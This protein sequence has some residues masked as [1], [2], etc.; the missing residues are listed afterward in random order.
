VPHKD[1]HLVLG[2]GHGASPETIKAAWR[3]LARE[4]HPDLTG[5][6]PAASQRA[7]RRMAEINAAYAALTRPNGRARTTGFDPDSQPAA[8]RSGR[9]G[10]PPRP[11]PTPP[12]TARVDMSATFQPRNQTTSP[13]RQRHPLP[14]QPP[15]RVD[16]TPPD[17][18]A[19]Q[20][21]GPTIRDRLADHVPYPAP[22]L[23]QA[24]VV[25]LPFGKFRGHTL[26]EI[27]AFE[28]SYIDWL[29]GTVARDP[30]LNAAARVVREELD[31]RGIQRVHR[32]PRPG[33]RSNPFV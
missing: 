5:D 16:R 29:A 18:R 17:L 7:T 32:P 4:N 12:V 11:R 21:S 15:L 20:P 3:R 2:V 31:R 1:P 23:E 33:W 22:T 6:D 27:A 14:G 24:L 13:P 19:S 9:R 30:E 26:E 28:P 25:E 10:G 8:A